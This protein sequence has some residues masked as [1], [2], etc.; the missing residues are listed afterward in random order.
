[1]KMD[2]TEVENR[3][4]AFLIDELEID[5]EKVNEDASMKDDLGIDSLDYVDVAV[6]VENEFGFK[7]KPTDMKGA[8]SLG[9]FI[10][11][12]HSCLK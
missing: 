5:P 3:V 7:P 12:I 6:F 8:A 9:Q 1:M 11:Y 2:R 4:R 10:S